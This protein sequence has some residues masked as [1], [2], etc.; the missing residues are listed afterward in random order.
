MYV[1]LSN[2]V[3]ECVY[4]FVCVCVFVHVCVC[5]SVCVRVCEWMYVCA[6]QIKGT[7]GSVV[8]STEVGLDVV[9]PGSQ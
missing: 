3:C 7:R 4:V 5:E 8:F 9:V 1:C 2:T 6:C